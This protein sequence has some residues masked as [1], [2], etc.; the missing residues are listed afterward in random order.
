MKKTKHNNIKLY[1]IVYYK[2]ILATIIHIYEDGVVEIELTINNKIITKTVK[3]G[4]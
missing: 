3:L 2:G 4:K 1:D